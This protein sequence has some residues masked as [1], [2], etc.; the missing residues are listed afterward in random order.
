[1]I[2]KN[3]DLPLLNRS[4]QWSFLAIPVPVEAQIDTLAKWNQ[5]AANQP[6][7]HNPLGQ[8][9]SY[10]IPLKINTFENLSPSS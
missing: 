4:Q 10:S 1:M 9:F 5:L 2:F 3:S 8:E 6:R 7:F